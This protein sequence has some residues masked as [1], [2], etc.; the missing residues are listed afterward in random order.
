MVYKETRVQRLLLLMVD[1]GGHERRP[2]LGHATIT[3]NL[4]GPGWVGRKAV[5]GSGGGGTQRWTQATVVGRRKRGRGSG[6]GKVRV[7]L[8]SKPTYGRI[9]YQCI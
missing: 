8:L 1:A 6:W 3:T 7:T 4:E 5:V 9:S 2:P